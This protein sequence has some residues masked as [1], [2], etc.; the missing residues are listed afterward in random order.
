MG[1][2]K[3]ISDRLPMVNRRVMAQYGTAMRISANE[4]QGERRKPNERSERGC[5][6]S[7]WCRGDET[8]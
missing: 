2:S 7:H 3:P 5:P 1:V 6:L 4:W 8:S